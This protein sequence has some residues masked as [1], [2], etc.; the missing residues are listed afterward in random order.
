MPDIYW[1]LLLA[2][3]VLTAVN[4]FAPQVRKMLKRNTIDYSSA[5]LN[6]A[7][8]NATADKFNEQEFKT[9][10]DFLRA[11]GIQITPEDEAQ[12][13]AEHKEIIRTAIICY[14]IKYEEQH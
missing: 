8:L 13:C 7:I 14:L 3:L 2:A 10:I 11:H 12:Y 4:I 5:L 1:G 6:D 9:A